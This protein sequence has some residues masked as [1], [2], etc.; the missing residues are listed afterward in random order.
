[1][2]GLGVTST[3]RG[4]LA[5]TFAA[6]AT[7]TVVGVAL[8]AAVSV[9]TYAG[10]DRVVDTLFSAYSTSVTLNQALAD[11]ETAFR[12][13]ALSGDEQ[14]LAGYLGALKR[15]RAAAARLPRAEEVFPGLRQRRLVVERATAA[16]RDEVVEP[17]IIDLRSGGTLGD[18]RLEE[19]RTRYADVRAAVREYRQAVLAERQDGVADLRRDQTLLAVLLAAGVTMLVVS[20][21][22]AWVA[23]RRW[24]TTPLA[25]L[26]G[27]VDRVEEGDLSRQVAIH[28]APEE[29]RVLAEQI[30]RMRV[31]ILHEFALA[32]E[33][34]AQALEARQLVEEQAEE[35]RRSNAELEQFAYVASHDLQEPLRKVASFCQLIE[36]R[37]KGQLDERGEQYI[38]FAVDGAKRMQ[39]LI[40]DLLAFSRV[41]RHTGDFEPVDLEEVVGHALRQLSASVEETDAVVTHDRLP[42]VHGEASLLTQL[43]QNLIG[44]GIKFRA[45]ETPRIHLGVRPAPGHPDMWE[46]SCADNGIG[47]DPQY[48]DK[49]FV[50]F[51]RLHGRDSYTGTGIGLAMCKKIV[52]HHGGR[53]WLDSAG[54]GRGATFRWTMP[55]SHADV[56][57]HPAGTA[58]SSDA[59]LAE[60]RTADDPAAGAA[61]RDLARGGRPG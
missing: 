55:M 48:E 35:L 1:M 49:I 25:Q 42:T 29:I 59:H 32:E 20:A 23:L 56:P 16:W 15:S 41:G 9:R 19:N 44:N 47:I 40:Q 36:R 22:F 60:E 12:A 13:Y 8:V 2:D 4:R 6:L 17:G 31:R 30:D 52:E 51:Q 21:A 45:A 3:L 57:H 11:Q 10:Q 50:I 28:D 38:E 61:G 5:L 53:L 58:G 14:F 27:E 18:E 24:V 33:S 7:L 26:G 54:G 43:M 34:R 37:Y 46:L 39:Q